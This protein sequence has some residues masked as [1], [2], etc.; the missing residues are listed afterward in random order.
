M[1][2][3]VATLPRALLAALTFHVN[4]L[5]A[6][7]GYLPANWDILWSLSV[8]EVF[9]FFFPLVRRHTT[10][11]LGLLFACF[12]LGPLSRTH[13][14]EV[15]REYSYLGGMDAIAMGCIT[16][17]LVSRIQI[18]ARV[19]A[20]IG[21]AILIF[22]L[23]FSLTANRLGG[24]TMTIL[25]LGTCMIISASAQTQWTSPRILSPLLALG[26]RSYEI[27]LTHM[28]VVFAFFQ[29]FF[30]AGKPMGGVPA[31]FIATV[32]VSAL[33]G[34]AV[35]RFYSEPLN[36]FLRKPKVRGTT[37]GKS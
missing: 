29:T 28:F 19:L 32:A 20:A 27:Y 35:A 37:L 5:E 36:Q 14:N 10:I 16:A 13:G 18:P 11:F 22:C 3:K 15:W 30:M 25:A 8:E 31:L 12:V 2:P 23:C 33:A 21:G 26:Q 24:F 34:A 1:N 17:L 7:R 9:Y 6:Q 4:V